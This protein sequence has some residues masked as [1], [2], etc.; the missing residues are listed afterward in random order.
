[1]DGT[2]YW[3][4]GSEV[5]YTNWD[6]ETSSE[7]SGVEYYG[8][9]W[10]KINWKWHDTTW[11][12]YEYAIC[13]KK[14]DTTQPTQVPPTKPT[15]VP[16]LL[17]TIQPTKAPTP[18]PTLVPTIQPTSA[19]TPTPTF[20]PTIKPTQA[21]TLVP[22]IQPTPA[23]LVPTIQPTSAP[24]PAPTLVPTIQPTSA[25]TT[26]SPSFMPTALPTT[27]TSLTSTDHFISLS[28]IEF[29]VCLVIF[30]VMCLCCAFLTFVI[31]TGTQKSRAFSHKFH[32]TSPNGESGQFTAVELHGGRV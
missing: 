23:T 14:E 28:M 10:N 6:N 24:T 12:R 22:T 2:W 11:D 18:T 15:S 25:P 31:C 17:P 26:S 32:L 1:M 8:A 27:P 5:D 7:P 4:D 9:V 19:P 30:I 16:T 3:I 13:S 20:V 29:L 21:P